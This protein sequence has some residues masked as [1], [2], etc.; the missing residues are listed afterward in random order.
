MHTPKQAAAWLQ[1]R[2][3]RDETAFRRRAG[4]SDALARLRSASEA[5]VYR[6]SGDRVDL[7][8]GR[9]LGGAALAPPR[10]AAAVQAFV[11]R[12]Y[13]DHRAVFGGSAFPDGS[14]RVE[15]VRSG[16]RTVADVR[17][18]VGDT[19]VEDARWTLVFDRDGY[20]T[21]VTGAPFDPVR[22]SVARQPKID[23]E[24]A[25]AAALEHESLAS[26]DVEASPRL[27]IQGRGNRLVWTVELKGRRRPALNP[28]LEVDAHS[29]AVLARHDGC[30]HA[31]GAIPVKH[32]SHPGGI[33]DSSASMITSNLNVDYVETSGPAKTPPNLPEGIWPIRTYSLQRLGSGRSRIW[34]AKPTGVDAT[35]VFHRTLSNDEGSFVRSPG[36]TTNNV[37]NE[38]QT[39]YWAQTLKTAV[40]LWGRE[41]NAFGHYPVDASRAVNVEIVVNGE[42]CMEEVWGSS[43]MHGFFLSGAPR[44]WFAGLGSSP[45]TAPAVFLFNS[46]GNSD[47]PQ[48]FGPEYSG[49]YSIIAHEVGHFISWQYGSWSGPAGTNLGRSFSEGHS[50]VI[51][52]LLGKQH[53]GAL[54]YD[55]SSYVTTGGK[56]SGRQWTHVADGATPSY[57]HSS[58]D[59]DDDS[60]PYLLAWPY[61][62]AMWRL[63][64]NRDTDGSPIWAT[65]AGAIANTAELFMHSLYTFTADSTM[66]WDKLCLALLAHLYDLIEDGR[67]QDPLPAS[68]SYCAVYR[69]FSAHGLLDE[70]V[71]SPS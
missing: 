35:P 7:L 8:V 40:D 65:S 18:H 31:V 29:R 55:E 20:L 64:N 68:D 43:V 52:A 62:Q 61:V 14:L 44:S 71:N 13:R 10:D 70:C 37:F 59:C 19:P 26:D 9:K 6:V 22:L 27:A 49:S 66:T 48:F 4:A 60:D 16:E 54:E 45:S 47:S 51:A 56:T 30:E 36:T 17:Q 2:L 33:K 38:Q 42:S 50:M 24:Q 3:V 69:V 53:F 15:H 67:E 46:E 11:N 58:L 32:Y 28:V 21:R 5:L 12:F 39:Y 23:A 34:N 1:E 63:M 25:V 41:P 57:K